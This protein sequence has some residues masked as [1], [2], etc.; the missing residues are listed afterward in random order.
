MSIKHS[1]RKL[2]KETWERYGRIRYKIEQVF[3]SIKQKI[4]SSFNLLRVG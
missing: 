2:S 3:G 4:G 1:L